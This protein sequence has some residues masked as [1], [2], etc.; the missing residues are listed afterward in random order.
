MQPTTTS[1]STMAKPSA[2]FPV[3]IPNAGNASKGLAMGDA[4]ELPVADG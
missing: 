1:I 2:S 3:A 4:V